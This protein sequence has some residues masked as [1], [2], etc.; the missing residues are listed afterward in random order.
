MTKEKCI[1][2]ASYLRNIA[3]GQ[4]LSP[5]G[6]YLWKRIPFGLKNATA[7]YQR[8]MENCLEGYYSTVL[9]PGD[10]VPVRNLS[11]RGGPGKLC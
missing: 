9:Q 11:E 7:T 10:R 5:W 1:I 4:H 3:T 6:L 8:Y 2:K